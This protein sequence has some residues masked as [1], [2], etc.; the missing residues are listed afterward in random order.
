M[1]RTIKDLEDDMGKADY[2]YLTKKSI[3]ELSEG[4]PIHCE[5]VILIPTKED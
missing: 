2:I 5:Q 1:K 4:L 3:K